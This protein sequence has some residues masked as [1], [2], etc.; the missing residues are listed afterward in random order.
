M[1]PVSWGLAGQTWISSRRTLALDESL[2]R[3]VL[4]FSPSVYC[5]LLSEG[6]KMPACVASL[7]WMNIPWRTPLTSAKPSPRCCCAAAGCSQLGEFGLPRPGSFS[8]PTRMSVPPR[9]I[10]IL[11]RLITMAASLARALMGQASSASVRVIAV[12]AFQ[13]R[14]AGADGPA[15]APECW[16]GAARLSQRNAAPPTGVGHCPEPPPAGQQAPARTRGPSRANVS[17]T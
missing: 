5:G 13:D 8:A 4:I 9:R 10:E 3:H 11:A 1:A 12:P 17:C 15:I 7:L 16:F 6:Q 2:P 14:L